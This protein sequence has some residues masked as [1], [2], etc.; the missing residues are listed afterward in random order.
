MLVL[1]RKTGEDVVF[2]TQ[3]IVVKVVEIRG[4]KVRLGISA[5]PGVPVHRR[6]VWVRMQEESA[7]DAACLRRPEEVAC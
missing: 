3:G 7:E 5:P 2:P 6:E 4:N 1:T